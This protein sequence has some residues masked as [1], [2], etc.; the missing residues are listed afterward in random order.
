M[1]IRKITLVIL[2]FAAVGVAN[3]QNPVERGNRTGGKGS[4]GSQ[5]HERVFRN[6]IQEIQKGIRD[7][8]QALHIYDGHRASASQYGAIAIAEL[9]IGRIENGR[10]A[11]M[12]KESDND[13]KKKYSDEQIRKSNANMN[14]ALKHYER[15]LVMLQKTTG[16]YNG[17]KVKAMQALTSGIEEIRK[18]LRFIGGQIN[19]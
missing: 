14:E 6:A 12:T 18:G 2:A 1:E 9:R 5:Q 8:H 16:D 10:Q 19:P 17:H 11:P 7:L 13:D 4:V 3:A 15:A